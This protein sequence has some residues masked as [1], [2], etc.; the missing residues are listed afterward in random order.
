LPR[1][2]QNVTWEDK[3]TLLVSRDWGT[4]TMSKAGY[5]IN[6]HEWKRGEPIEKSKEV[7]RGIQTTTDMATQP[8][9]DGW[10]GTPVSPGMEKRVVV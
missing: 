10:T 6:V 4:G 8:G 7:Y 3:D 2:K 1:G 5:P 9:S